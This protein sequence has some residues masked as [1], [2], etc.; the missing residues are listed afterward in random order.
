MV[1]SKIQRRT[2]IL[3]L[4]LP[5]TMQAQ[6]CRNSLTGDSS[7]T[8]CDFTFSAIPTYANS[9]FGVL[10]TGIYTIRNNTPVAV[11]INY[12]RIKDNDALPDSA[13]AIVAAPTNNCV[14]GSSLAS[15]ASCN[16]QLNLIPL[17][18]GTFSRILQ[19]GINSRQV[20]I[21]APTIAAVITA[22]P[23]PPPPL[24]PVPGDGN[25]PTPFPAAL[26]N[27]TIYSYAAVTNTGPSI[28]NGDVNVS[29]GT[30]ITGFP[31]GIIVNGGPIVPPLSNPVVAPINAY[32]TALNALPCDVTFAGSTF[33]GGQTLTPGVYC[34]TSTALLTG[35]LN[36]TGG[37][38]SS[39]TFKIAT[40]LTTASASSIVLSGGLTSGNV[41][42]AIGTAATLGTGTAFQGNIVAG[43]AITLTTGS[44]LIG[45]AW[46]LTEAV[47]LDTNLVGP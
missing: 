30:S 2:I 14:V 19:V 33:G 25:A 18:A 34:F 29:P 10:Q 37:V 23:P 46:A 11:R 6:Q 13:T 26:Q 32:Y 5:L 44:T 20:E 28:V 4:L 41:N 40:A 7:I 17:T 38:N 45:R 21:D 31:P 15:G 24:P 12:I 22:C 1:I 39:Y 3:G 47:T 9:C 36:L 42:W 16:I 27:A 8:A 43:S 35:A